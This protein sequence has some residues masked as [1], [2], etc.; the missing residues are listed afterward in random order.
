M[1]AGEKKQKRE[2]SK[3]KLNSKRKTETYFGK[4]AS[5]VLFYVNRRRPQVN[6]TSQ[7]RHKCL[8]VT[9]GYGISPI[10]AEKLEWWIYCI[11][12][13]TLN[14]VCV[15]QFNWSHEIDGQTSRQQ[16]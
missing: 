1:K 12:K 15:G 7:K 5:D 16:W 11:T 8:S 10:S 4:Q 6:I 2:I 3:R 14:T 9:Q 13:I